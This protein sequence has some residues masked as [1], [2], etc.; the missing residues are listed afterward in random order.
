MEVYK[1]DVFQCTFQTLEKPWLKN[2]TNESGIKP[3]WY[4]VEHYNSN[5]HPNTFHV[6]NVDGRTYILIHSGSYFTHTAGCILIGLAYTDLNKD[7][8]MDLI[9]SKE[10]MSILN[11]ICDGEEIITLEYT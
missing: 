2:K 1:D 8:Y 3:D 5:K 10:A 11:K 6:M 4:Q 9:H 7:G